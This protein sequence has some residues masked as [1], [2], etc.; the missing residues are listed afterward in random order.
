MKIFLMVLFGALL[1]FGITAIADRLYGVES[2]L[3]R[4]EKQRPVQSTNAAV[5]MRGVKHW[6]VQFD[7]TN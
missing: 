1:A 2:R 3:D 7:T 5:N 4:L 6:T